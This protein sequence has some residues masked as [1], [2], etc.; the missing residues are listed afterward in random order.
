MENPPSLDRVPLSAVPRR[1]QHYEGA[2]T[3]TRRITGHLFGSLP[4]PTRFLHVSCSPMPALPGG[5]RSRIE[6]GSL[7]DRRSP[8]PVHSHVDV[9]G[10]SQVPR[11]SILCLCPGLG[12]RPNRRHLAI[13]TVPSMMPPQHR[14]RRLQRTFISRPPRGFS[15]CCLRFKNDVATIPARLASGWLAGLCRERVEPSGPR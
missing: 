5:W 7:F 1:H 10:T 14:T 11:R 4:V 6:P 9:S 12:S 15:T 13:E 2:T 8:L 3:P